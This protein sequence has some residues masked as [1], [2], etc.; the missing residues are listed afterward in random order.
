MLRCGRTQGREASPTTAIIDSQTAKG[1]VKGGLRSTRRSMKGGLA[2]KVLGRK[3]HVLTDTQLACC[4]PFTSTPPGVQDRDGA[5]AR[6]PRG[7]T[8][9]RILPREIE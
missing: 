5:E 2:K 9:K 8:E 7:P 1:A 6:G 3:R 4:W